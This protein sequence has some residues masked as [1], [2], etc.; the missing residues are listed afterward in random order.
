M[1][2]AL[3]WHPVMPEHLPAVVQV[4]QRSYSHPWTRG[5]LED[6]IWSGHHCQS[7]WLAGAAQRGFGVAD[8]V[9]YS[10]SMPG[11]DEAHLLNITVAP[12]HQRAGHAV[13]LLRA[14]CT[15]ANKAKLPWLWLEVRRS[16]GRAFDIYRRFGFAQVGERKDYYPLL[17]GREDALVMNLE[18]ARVV[19]LVPLVPVV[20]L[21]QRVPAR[22]AIGAQTATDFTGAAP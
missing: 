14:V 15:W 8:L 9:G 4:E 16:N 5:N 1:T 7:L 13:S 21:A 10:I 22:A 2:R 6:S 12:D 17:H 18:V 19:P 20:Q 3:E 11:V